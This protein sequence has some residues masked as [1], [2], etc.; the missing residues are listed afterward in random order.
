VPH[1]I[2]LDGKGR[3]Y[4]ADRE[5]SRVQVFSEKGDFINQ[6]VSRVGAGLNRFTGSMRHATRQWSTHVSSISYSPAHDIFAVTEGDSVVLRTSSGCEFSSVGG[7]N[8]PHDA[9]LLPGSEQRS[10]LGGATGWAVVV[11]EL[12]GRRVAKLDPSRSASRSAFDLYG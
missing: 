6:W 8:W 1:S 9:V 2:T 5:N 7:F 11:A 4:V 10:V 12:D 3:V